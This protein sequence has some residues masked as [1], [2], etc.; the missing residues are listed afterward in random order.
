MVIGPARRLQGL[1]H[2]PNETDVNLVRARRPKDRFTKE[3][4]SDLPMIDEGVFIG[5]VFLV[6][7]SGDG[8]NP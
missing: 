2:P 1:Q 6:W 7:P 5:T 4:A 3:L 8:G